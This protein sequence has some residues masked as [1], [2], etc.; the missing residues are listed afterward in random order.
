MS[1]ADAAA[2]LAALNTTVLGAVDGWNQHHPQRLP[3]RKELASIK[4]TER[5]VGTVVI[6][7]IT[8][9]CKLASPDPMAFHGPNLAKVAECA[10][11]TVERKIES[12][13][14]RHEQKASDD[15]QFVQ[16]FGIAS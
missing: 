5:H 13:L 11:L 14:R 1:Q 15:A 16:R 12:E 2:Q 9:K 3:S 6:Y 4:I 10:R 8:I 7:S